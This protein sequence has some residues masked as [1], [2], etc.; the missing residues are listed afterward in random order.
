[1][2]PKSPNSEPGYVTETIDTLD[3]YYRTYPEYYD[4]TCFQD[5]PQLDPSV[6]TEAL[7]RSSN[8]SIVTPPVGA[9]AI[10]QFAQY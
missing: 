8:A 1:M 2:R 5:W 3:A 9:I 4:P 6:P 10:G 7:R